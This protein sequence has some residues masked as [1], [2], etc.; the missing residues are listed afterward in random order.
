MGSTRLPG[1]VLAPLRGRP[2]LAWQLE[3]L[4]A[5]R[6]VDD[7]VVATSDAPADDPIEDL[8]RRAGVGCFR[9]PERDVLRRYA[10][11]ARA[12]AADVVARV[13]GDCPLVDAAV[14]DAVIAGLVDASPP[15]DYASNVLER[16]WPRGLDV[17][18]LHRDALERCDRM[19]T[20]AAA[21]EH[22]TWFIVEERPELFV[23]R[24]IT[25]AGRN[26]D[27]RWTVD[28]PEDLEMMRQLFDAAGIDAP[29]ASYPELLAHVRAHPELAA[30]N[31]GVAQKRAAS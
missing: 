16:T 9:G 27:L 20:S 21:R 18:A 11:A 19:A 12:A 1:K 7:I 28:T 23:R 6:R 24:S 31:A 30:I 13:T 14:A 15:C 4:A 2:M 5:C 8:A 10:G 3:R 22:V 25:D 29:R 26:A 17:E